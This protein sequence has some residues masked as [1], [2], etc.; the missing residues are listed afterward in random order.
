[1]ESMFS[2]DTA[3]K[4]FT[5]TLA[6]GEVVNSNVPW[7]VTFVE[8][9]SDYRLFVR[10]I[11]GLEGEV[12]MSG[13]IFS[14]KAGVFASLRNPEEF[15]RVGCSHGFVE[16]ENGVDIAPDATHEDIQTYGVRILN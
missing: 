3:R 1:M 9:R 10:F 14:D 13:Q 6:S 15:Q 7:V 4:N 12:H 16:W 2:T 11:D 8:P 5:A